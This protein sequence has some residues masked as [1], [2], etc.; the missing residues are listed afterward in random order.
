MKRNCK[1]QGTMGCNG[2]GNRCSNQKSELDF[3]QAS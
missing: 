1:I 2:L 3:G